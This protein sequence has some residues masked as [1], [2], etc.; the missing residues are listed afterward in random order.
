METSAISYRVADFLKKHP[1]FHAIDE[2]DL[3]GLA[4]RGRVRFYEA[5]QF[6]LW[7]GEPHRTHVFV[8]QQGTVSLW[9]EA[10]ARSGLHDILG[11]GD[12]LGVERFAG[13]PSCAYSARAGSDVVVY[14]F[15]AEDFAD[16]L[17]KYPHALHY[18][19][20]TSG[21]AAGYE[22]AGSRQQPHEIF[23][24]DLVR[25]KTLHTCLEHES[26][27]D[28]ARR[29]LGGVD[30]IAV[31]DGQQ[32]PL[33]IIT[34]HD[35]LTWIATNGGSGDQPVESL[36]FKSLC[37]V[38][39][40]AV[41]ADSVV[42]MGTARADALAITADGTPDGRLHA[43]VTARD[44]AP[45]FGDQPALI[46]RE[47]ETARDFGELRALNLRARA[48]AL[49]HLS[50]TASLEWLARFTHAVDVAIVGRTL[51]FANDQMAV[52]ACVCFSGAAGRAESL[53]LAAP[54]PV[55]IVDDNVDREK[56][57][58]W[59]QH[60]LDGLQACGYLTLSEVPF[61]QPFYVAGVTDWKQ[62]YAEWIRDPI[63]RQTY[64][65][66]P[67]F[68]LK[69]VHGTYSLWQD[70]ATTVASAIDRDFLHVMS[71]DCL[72]NLPPLTFF[73]DAVVEDTGEFATVFRLDES[74]LSPLVDVGRV[75][76]MAAGAALGCS[77]FERFAGARSLFATHESIFRDAAETLR[78]V[79]W[80]QARVGIAQGTEGT[81]LPPT[82]LSR[83]DRHLL[84]GS[85]RSILR[86]AQFAANPS[87][88]R[89][90]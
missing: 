64:K 19:T 1:P 3:V 79:L 14:T 16:L 62:R 5:N 26:V 18:V 72:A 11:A 49:H 43:I 42:K 73:E 12:M 10:D 54:R 25:R 81:E 70:V 4:A 51:A 9:D 35:L 52:P 6:V 59:Y 75:F 50:G 65:A 57:L 86:L 76:G 82:A 36:P 47:V 74:V 56:A 88:I 89:E 38:A 13:A 67:L 23:L 27:R 24:H 21:V 78:L 41:V 15:P 87:W 58:A 48:F 8:I 84:K 32:R 83:Q 53:T 90:L 31:V 55:L 45:A 39:P 66:R 34:A 71:N 30:A 77:T 60:L 17:E 68:D 20:A 61:D 40:D 2:A 29:L 85:F 69:A 7:Q 28:A 22:P 63:L 46:L 33:G 44:M 37:S 80:Q